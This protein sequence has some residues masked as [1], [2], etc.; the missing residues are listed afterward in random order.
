VWVIC[1][2]IIGNLGYLF[3]Y[4]KRI[5]PSPFGDGGTI[6]LERMLSGWGGCGWMSNCGRKGGRG[7][8][9]GGVAVLTGYRKW[10]ST[11]EWFLYP[12]AIKEVKSLL[13][14][15]GHVLV[16]GGRWHHK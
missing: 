16:L 3:H 9:C 5:P 10:F 1:C 4:K 11:Q 7:G 15:R 14:Q 6:A 13:S 12:S 2:I 8:I